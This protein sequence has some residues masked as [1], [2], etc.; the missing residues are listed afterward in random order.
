[1]YWDASK[2]EDRGVILAFLRPLT[3]FT[4]G[5]LSGGGVFSFNEP[6][7]NL[8]MFDGLPSRSDGELLLLPSWYQDVVVAVPSVAVESWN[9]VL[10]A[11]PLVECR[12]RREELLISCKILTGLGGRSSPRTVLLSDVHGAFSLLMTSVTP[13]CSNTGLV[14]GEKGLIRR[15]D[16]NGARNPTLRNC[17][18]LF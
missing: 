1:M 3:S 6:W 5:Q 4:N 13:A 7:R 12:D 16:I 9:M 18:L 8:V 11:G 14:F 10:S 17:S 15:P 2:L